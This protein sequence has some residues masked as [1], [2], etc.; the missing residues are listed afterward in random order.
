MN[1]FGR[2]Q[3]SRI[4]GRLPLPVMLSL[5][6]LLGLVPAGLL[7]KLFVEQSMKD[8]D[9]AQREIAG[10]RYLRPSWTAY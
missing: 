2:L 8:V 10:L 3:L 4:F 6:L 9:F 1:P 7:G 5:L